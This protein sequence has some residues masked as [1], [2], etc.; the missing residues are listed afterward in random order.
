M[1]RA[2]AK[3]YKL[4]AIET[5]NK[6]QMYGDSQKHINRNVRTRTQKRDIPSQNAPDPNRL[7]QSAAAANRSVRVPR[8]KGRF[9]SLLENIIPH[10]ELLPSTSNIEVTACHSA[11]RHGKLNERHYRVSCR[12]EGGGRRQGAGRASKKKGGQAGLQHGAHQD[13]FVCTSEL[14]RTKKLEAGMAPPTPRAIA[15]PIIFSTCI[16]PSCA[17]SLISI[18]CAQ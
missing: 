2:I 10:E 11:Q 7:K 1:S 13:G 4:G 6:M 17:P 14:A 8:K 3:L 18:A 12:Q 15:L 5:F 16:A 9:P